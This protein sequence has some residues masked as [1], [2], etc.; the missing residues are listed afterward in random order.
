MASV[1]KR[2]SSKFWTASY[3]DRNGK[4]I[5]KCTKLTERNKAGT[6]ADKWESD[7]T[8]EESARLIT[9][10]LAD[11]EAKLKAKHNGETRHIGDTLRMIREFSAACTWKTASDISETAANRQ[12]VKMQEDG[13]SARTIQAWLTAVK[14]FT[15]WLATAGRLTADP[16]AGLSKPNPKKDRKL[17]RRML[18]PDEWHWLKTTTANSPIRSGITANERA[19]LYETAIQT[20]LRANELQQLTKNS[21]HL[22]AKRPFIL[23]RAGTTKND[24]DARQYVTADLAEALRKHVAK[25]PAKGPV[26]DMPTNMRHADMLRADL[27]DA[28]QAWLDA[29]DDA[30]ELNKRQESDFLLHENEAGETLD[31]HALRHTCGAWLAKSGTQPKVVQT[32]MRHYSITLTMD[33]YGHL[34]PG[35]EADAIDRLGSFL[36]EHSESA[37][38]AAQ[39]AEQKNASGK[40]AREESALEESQPGS[41][42]KPL[43][44]AGIDNA[45]RV[46]ATPDQSSPART[47]TWD[48]RINSPLLYQ[49]SYRGIDVKV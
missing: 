32:V 31:F 22:D 43:R 46:E 11:Y 1:F 39:R 38:R 45:L 29:A 18:L 9:L 36:G 4:R 25:K 6:L 14:G 19:L 30:K 49:L 13:S 41:E 44:L 16:L 37:Q 7:T 26:F 47:R 8:T 28:R 23:A 24:K 21:L 15:R 2:G 5:T 42:P 20:G 48:T 12:I 35:E 3:Y 40:T 34:F 33:T 27:A 10:H 17:E